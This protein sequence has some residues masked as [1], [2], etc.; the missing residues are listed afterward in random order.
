MSFILFLIKHTNPYKNE[1][2]RI[3]CSSSVPRKSIKGHASIL[4]G[5][6]VFTQ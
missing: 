6:I 4:V 5:L 2:I 3:D 1:D